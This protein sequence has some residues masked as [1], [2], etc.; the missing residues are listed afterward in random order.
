MTGA[1]VDLLN[2]PSYTFNAKMT[3]YAS[4]FRLVFV[5]NEEGGASTGSA[6]DAPFAFVDADGNII[7]NGEGVLQV[8]DVM[9]HIVVCRDAC[10]ASLSTS[11]MTPGVY[12]LRL[13]DGNNVKT[14]K[15][16]VR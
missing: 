6:T 4:R 7:I 15:I 2:T 8:V 12:V 1:D 11:E 14:Q 9:G 13:I 3:D 5:A 16:V 10:N